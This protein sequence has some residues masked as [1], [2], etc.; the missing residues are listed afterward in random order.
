MVYAR[1]SETYIDFTLIYT[2]Y[3]IF[4]VLIIKDLV[5]EDGEPT[6]SYKLAAG[7]EP[8]IF[9]LRLLFCLCIVRKATSYVGTKAL[10]MC[11][12]AQKVFRGIFVE[13]PQHQKWYIF[14]VPRKR[15]I[16]SLYNVVF[17]ESLSSALVYTSQL[18]VEA[19]A[20]QLA[21]SYIPYA[22]SPRGK[23]AI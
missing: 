7:M 15:K 18:Y 6:S 8:S 13:I 5:N 22:T 19:M 2:A 9:N 1:V 11:H 10:N 20:M 23:L 4:S 16:V 21:V 3:H 17:D 14:Y 12:Q